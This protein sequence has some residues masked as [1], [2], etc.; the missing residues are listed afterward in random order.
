LRDRRAWTADKQYNGELDGYPLYSPEGLAAIA[1]DP[2]YQARI[3]ACVN[4]HES[5]I[6]A[7]EQ[8]QVEI[9]QLRWRVFGNGIPGTTQAQIDEALKHAREGE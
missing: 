2:E 9:R 4:A 6:A 5:L 1:T 8:A 7:L 3:L